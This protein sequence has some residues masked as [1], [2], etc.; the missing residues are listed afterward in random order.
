[1]L[2]EDPGSRDC[3]EKLAKYCATI[4]TSEVGYEENERSGYERPVREIGIFAMMD[5][6]PRYQFGRIKDE[7]ISNGNFTYENTEFFGGGLHWM[8]EAINMRGK[9]SYSI[10]EY[11]GKLWRSTEARY[12]WIVAVSDPRDAMNELPQY[13]LAHYRVAA[14]EYKAINRRDGSAKEIHNHMLERAQEYPIVLAI[15]VDIQMIEIILLFRDAEKSGSFGSV[16]MFLSAIRLSLPFMAAAHAYRY[17][18]IGCDFL[19]W[20]RFA[21]EAEKIIFGRYLF[22]KLSSY[23]KPIYSDR[24]MELSVNFCAKRLEVIILVGI[25]DAQMTAPSIL[26]KET[27]QHKLT[28]VTTRPSVVLSWN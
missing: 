25:S 6:S 4:A 22:T 2:H 11:W 20:Y 5:G 3:V 26:C 24:C 21:S 15:L 27:S 9:L 16:E 13:V 23:G 28:L 10:F 17:V 7:D 1:V 14:D 18:R 19:D 8:M 12:N